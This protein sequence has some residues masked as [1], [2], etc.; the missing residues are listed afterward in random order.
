MAT[1]KRGSLKIKKK[2]PLN[3]RY[4]PEEIR[5]KQISSRYRSRVNSNIKSRKR[6]TYFDYN[7]LFVVI[8]LLCFG[9]IMLYS[10]SYYTGINKFNDSTFYLKK[11]LR[12]IIIGFFAMYFVV[13]I[14]YK[15]LRQYAAGLLVMSTLMCL[16]VYVPK[17]GIERNG[18]RRWIGFGSLTVQPSEIAKVCIIIFLAY[19]LE[20][21]TKKM[22]SVAGIVCSLIF[23]APILILVAK[24][25]L[26]TAIIIA[27]IA[28]C[29]IF[30]ASPL[31]KEFLGLL[32]IGGCVMVLFILLG[33]SYRGDRIEAWLSP[34]KA[35]V[36]GDQTLQG[37]YA[38][39]SGGLTGRGLGNS[40]QKMGR[41]PEA[42]N[43]MIFSIVCEELGLIGATCLL[44]LFLL[45]IWRMMIISNNASDLFGSL[46]VTGVMAHIAL[47][48]ILN[49][50][51][52]TNTIPNTGVTLPFISYGGTSIII[53][54][55]EMGL[56]L[57]VSRGIKLENNNEVERHE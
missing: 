44:L 28:F 55:A 2:K 5:K 42:Q 1:S 8:F 46:I 39:C 35:G 48:V 47:Q 23:I 45:L 51:V 19:L 11:Q 4:T 30:V 38:I 49:V 52:V 16:L 10:T 29:M 56:V 57:S 18:S 37:L 31:Y 13:R 17:I 20:R 40:M 34:E 26:S 21:I 15:K 3:H 32:G 25:N 33:H 24:E 9:L 54:M 43:D 7:F 22:S 27:G 50:A 6:T 12:S 41:V 14:N 36:K 53:L